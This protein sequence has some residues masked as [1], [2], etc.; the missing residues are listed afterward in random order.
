MCG[1]CKAKPTKQRPQEAPNLADFQLLPNAPAQVIPNGTQTQEVQPAP[2]GG[3]M[4]NVQTDQTPVV[5]NGPSLMSMSN[6]N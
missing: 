6:T 5:D 2:E 4:A 3:S 1:F